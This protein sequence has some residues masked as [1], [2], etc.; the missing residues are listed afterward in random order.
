MR[1]ETSTTEVHSCGKSE[2]YLLYCHLSFDI[3]VERASDSTNI[4]FG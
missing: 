1:L 2:V 3:W 4:A